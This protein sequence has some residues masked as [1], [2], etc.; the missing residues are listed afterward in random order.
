MATNKKIT[1]Q[2]ADNGLLQL[3]ERLKKQSDEIYNKTVNQ[4]KKLSDSGREQL[5][6]IELQAKALERKNS[7]LE[8]E[9]K[10]LEETHRSN[11]L[12]INREQQAGRLTPSQATAQRKDLIQQRGEKIAEINSTIESQEQ[13]VSLLREL[14]ETVKLTARENLAEDKKQAE[15]NVRQ[16]DRQRARGRVEDLDPTQALVTGVQR[17]L[18][19]GDRKTS[20]MMM[21]MLKANLLT[22]GIKSIGR[23][24]KN[25]V[26]TIVSAQEG[27]ETLLPNLV[28]GFSPFGIP[29]GQIIAEPY[30]RHL[31]AQFSFDRA[32]GLNVATS[33]RGLNTGSLVGMGYTLEE[34]QEMGREVILARGTGRGGVSNTRDALTLERGMGLDRGIIMQMLRDMRMVGDNMDMVRNTASVLNVM[35]VDFRDRALT[36]E[37]LQAQ[38]SLI[39]QQGGR[40]MNVNRGGITGMMGAF[41]GLGGRFSSDPSFL[42]NT[43]S[44]VNQAFINPQNEFAQARQFGIMSQLNPNAS[45]FQ[46]QEM[47]EKGI[48]QSGMLG[49]T[50]E[51][52]QRE[53]GQDPESM[54]LAFKQMTGVG[55]DTSRAII[56]G[57]MLDP[58]RFKGFAGSEKDAF[59]MLGIATEGKIRGEALSDEVL[60]SRVKNIAEV[61]DAFIEGGLKGMETL[62]KQFAKEMI[63]TIEDADINLNILGFKF[64]SKDIADKLKAMGQ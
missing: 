42:Q 30:M 38:S 26:G 48:F 9:R 45:Y 60:P 8:R 36:G 56:E 21:D 43:I 28:K 63:K 58:N 16:E 37:L 6:F 1:F 50:L 59:D 5:S 18:I 49:A 33:G 27:A 29:V 4:A 11:I 39:Q 41:G 13:S 25:G 53:M 2:G 52:L 44:T 51:S 17:D 57:F 35:G 3:M 7:Q 47:Q 55:A 31:E 64:G 24:I 15:R 12:A 62:G 23:G 22:E 46:M 54:M 10:I 32:K 19:G 34:G 40:T 14:I 61:Q 20:S